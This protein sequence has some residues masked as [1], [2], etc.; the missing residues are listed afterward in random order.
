MAFLVYF[1]MVQHT[2]LV[3]T[4]EV[5]MNTSPFAALDALKV[6]LDANRPLPPH[7]VSQLHEDIRIRFTY[8]SNAI[9]G[10]TLTIYETKAVLEDGITI[11]G[12]SMREHLETID[13]S[14]A[15][16]YL[17]TLVLQNEPLSERV[18]KEMHNII[19]RNI[20]NAN[21]GKYR[22]LNVMI[23]G[24]SH[25]PPSA[26]Q[27]P[28]KME[29]FFHWYEAER[30][31]LHPVELAARVHADFVNIHPFKDGNGRTARLI[32]NLELMKAGFPTVIIPVESRPEYYKNLDISATQGDYSPF[33][34]QVAD[35][36]AK[37]FEPYWRLLES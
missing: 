36:T 9:E 19:M 32:M 13:H 16:E 30:E 31:F 12:K 10:N 29:E 7:I 11:G 33:T 25:V 27:V 3:I 6:K 15:I 22:D 17:E 23:T 34:A 8:H 1:R 28:E 14:H 35:L 24:A 5:F 4:H 21:A 2:A 37:S 26:T 18:L 20:D